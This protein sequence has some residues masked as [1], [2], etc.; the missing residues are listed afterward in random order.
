MILRHFGM[1]NKSKSLTWP[2]S[3]C[4]GGAAELVVVC[5]D[6]VEVVEWTVDVG[7]VLVVEWVV[8]VG[9]VLVVE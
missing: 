3:V 1:C 5:T 2:Y 7:V 9:V 6:V 4:A 8:D